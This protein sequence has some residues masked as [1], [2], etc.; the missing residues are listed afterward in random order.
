MAVTL[1]PKGMEA[2]ARFPSC[3]LVTHTPLGRKQGPNPVILLGMERGNPVSLPLGGQ[4]PAR[5]AY[6]GAG[7]G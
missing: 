1:E 6:G 4:Q 3:L 5:S 7:V 2:G